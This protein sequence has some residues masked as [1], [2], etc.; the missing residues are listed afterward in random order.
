MS[1]N[2]LAQEDIDSLELDLFD[3]IKKFHPDLDENS[4]WDDLCA[5]VEKHLD[6]FSIGYRNY[7]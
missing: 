1:T 5:I 2:Q 7:N 3:F 6:K 4:D